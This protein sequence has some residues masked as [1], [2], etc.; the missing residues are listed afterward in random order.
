MRTINSRRQ[1][2]SRSRRFVTTAVG[3]AMLVHAA[4]VRAGTDDDIQALQ[5]AQQETRQRLN[6]LEGSVQ[7]QGLLEMA[8]M[9]ERLQTEVRQLRGQIEQQAHELEQ[10]RKRQRDLYLDID[11]RLG[12]LQLQGAPG[13][14]SG[15]NTAVQ[16]G[17]GA[18][19]GGGSDGAPSAANAERERADYKSAFEILREGRYEEA[20][21]AFSAFL[22]KYPDGGYADN[23]QYWLGEA[24]YVSRKFD[25]AAGEF[26]KVVEQHP[27]STKVPDAKLKLGYTYYELKQWDK[28]RGVLNDIL[29]SHPSTS[30]APLAEK[31]LM[32]M[33][34]EGH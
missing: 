10:M 32:R 16:A 11:R 2:P 12:D 9:L 17:G 23:A 20:I 26:R 1:R 28:A 5:I 18:S 14:G 7:N 3:L 6:K 4:A 19:A 15:N 13:T 29:D 31:R 34:G 8:Q 21:E 27:D 22:Q 24:Y 25:Q 30:V 33:S